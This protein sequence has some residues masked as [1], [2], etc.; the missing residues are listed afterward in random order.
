MPNGYA[1]TYFGSIDGA[2]DDVR[3]GQLKPISG[4][5]TPDD[6]TLVFKLTEPRRRRWSSRRW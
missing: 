6:H 2:P 4:I 5:Q 1:G 3:H